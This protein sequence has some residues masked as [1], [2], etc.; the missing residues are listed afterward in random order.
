MSYAMTK[1][2]L[3]VVIKRSMFPNNELRP[4]ENEIDKVEVSG[5]PFFPPHTGDKR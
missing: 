2:E 1:L 3:Q 5:P 4:N